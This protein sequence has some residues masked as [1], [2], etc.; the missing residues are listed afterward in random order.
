M[1]KVVILSLSCVVIIILVLLLNLSGKKPF[2]DLQTEDVIKVEVLVQ[3]PNTTKEILDSTQIQKLVEI[4]NKVV[5]YKKDNSWKE[6]NGQYIRYTITKKNSEIITIGV[7]NPFLIINDVG[8]KT[9]YQ[10]CE[11]LNALANFII[12]K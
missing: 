7:Y 12:G 1:K 5:I 8:Y 6:Y 2:K 3:P 9:K 11:D 10:P 4:L